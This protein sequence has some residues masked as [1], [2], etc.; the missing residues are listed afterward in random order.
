MAEKNSEKKL[1]EANFEVSS[2]SE[3]KDENGNGIFHLRGKT[4]IILFI[5]TLILL[6]A[7]ALIYFFV[8]KYIDAEMWQVALWGICAVTAIYSMFAKSIWAVIL[9]LVLFA[10]LSFIPTWQSGYEFFKPSIEKFTTEP[11]EEKNNSEIEN[12]TEKNSA[13]ENKIE[14]KISPLEEKNNSKIEKSQTEKSEIENS[15]EKNSSAENKI[16]EKNSTQEKNS[17]SEKIL[18]P[19]NKNSSESNNF[20][21]ELPTI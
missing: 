12:S 2:L 17:E 16:E 1:E 10:G 15:T 9:N 21:Q 8:E 19:E 6:A 7:A 18:E 4:K 5:S 3:V 11:V 14:E 13:T 20:S